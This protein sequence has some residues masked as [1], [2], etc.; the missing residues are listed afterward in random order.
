MKD[1]TRKELLNLLDEAL[2]CLE[3]YYRYGEEM[4]KIGRGYSGT[5]SKG[6]SIQGVLKEIKR[7]LDNTIK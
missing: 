7:A 4:R 3:D 6:Q 2:Y 1:L 5:G